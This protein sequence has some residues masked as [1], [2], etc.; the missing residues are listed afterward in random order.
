MGKYTTFLEEKS[1][2]LFNEDDY[3][4][5]LKTV[6]GD[7]RSFDEALDS[8]IL[9]HGYEGDIGNVDDKVAYISGKCK[10]AG[11]PVPRNLKKWYTEHKRMERN[12]AIPFHICFAFELSVEEV[13]D[14]LRRIC[15]SRGF[16]CH[17]V[18]EVVYF[19]AFK[20]GLKYE[21]VQD[22]LSKVPKVKADKLS[23][24]DFVYTDLIVDEIDEIESVDELVRY[25]NEN[26]DKFGYNNATACETIKSI[27]EQLVGTKEKSG[28]AMRE[29]KLMY[30]AFDKE[31]EAQAYYET[32]RGRKER[33]RSDDSIWEIY[34][35]ILGL[36]GSYSAEF[37]KDRSLK[38]ML[39]ENELLHPLAE[40]S[41]PDRDGLV[42]ILTGEHVSY[43]RV[44]KLLILLNFYQYYVSR[45]LAK[46]S[47]AVKEE[48]AERC[49]ATIDSNLTLSNYPTLYPGNPYDFLILMAIRT[50]Q[51]LPNFREYMRE[52]F[53]ESVDLDS[54]YE[55]N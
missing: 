37:Y 18:E 34:L 21:S 2:T 15:L 22:I 14:F 38:S 36:A 19:Y 11:V 26:V 44:R 40:E 43:E 41:F 46:N 1:I 55:G 39:K 3:L 29:K 28:F 4:E 50:E 23:Y 10:T 52:L 20:N 45:A 25:L 6:I 53:Y 42:K 51:P 33:K 32:Q 12:T 31:A 47:Y 13:N 49:I 35:Q 9:E 16:D 24:E 54:F 7:F 8:F 48:E 5:E 30:D 27:W 17:S